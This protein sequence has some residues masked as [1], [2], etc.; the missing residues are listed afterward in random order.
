MPATVVQPGWRRAFIAHLSGR[1]RFRIWIS[2]SADPF[3]RTVRQLIARI[4][5]K[6]WFLLSS[7]A[8]WNQGCVEIENPIGCECIFYPWRRSLS[9]QPSALWSPNWSSSRRKGSWIAGGLQSISV[10][11][12]TTCT[13]RNISTTTLRHPKYPRRSSK[14]FASPKWIHEE[15]HKDEKMALKW[16]RPSAHWMISYLWHLSIIGSFQSIQAVDLVH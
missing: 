11:P 14:D 8:P 7:L 16:R 9:C 2:E 6:G 10:G 4:T 3:R 5:F 15:L 13:T 1:V 12:L